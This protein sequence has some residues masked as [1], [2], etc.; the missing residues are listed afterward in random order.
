MNIV[1]IDTSDNKKI[2]VGLRIGEKEYKKEQEIGKQKAQ[3]VLPMIDEILQEHKLNLKDLHGIE[4]NTGPGSFTGLRVGC[5][6]AN[7]LGV[8]LQV[9]INKN[10][11]GKIAEPRYT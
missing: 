7:A 6:V 10:L 5:S 4:V 9:P 2:S 11:V 3:V 8:V 1:L